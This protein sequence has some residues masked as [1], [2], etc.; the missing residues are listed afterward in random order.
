M[1]I[2]QARTDLTPLGSREGG[3]R[4]F[5]LIELMVVVTLMGLLAAAVV[6]NLPDPRGRLTDTAERFA[7]RVAASRDRAVIEQR[8]MGLYV[9]PSGY[10][11]EGWREGRWEPF[12]DGPFASAQWPS[13][14]TL[15]AAGGQPG[16]RFAFDALG[17][18]DQPVDVV[19]SRD[20]E[21]VTVV[22]DAGGDVAVR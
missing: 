17:L 13:G 20:G 2:S 1:P 22:V 15:V 11:F 9:T 8:P 4:G 16:A 5:T 19:L 7:A 21:R 14:T 12:S 6:V 18:P 10:G 3:E